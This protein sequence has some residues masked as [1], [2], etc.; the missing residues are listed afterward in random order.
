MGSRHGSPLERGA[1][2]SLGR[3]ARLALVRSVD[4]ALQAK[5]VAFGRTRVNVDAVDA[6]RRRAEEALDLGGFGRFH[7][8]NLQICTGLHRDLLDYGQ[9]PL[10]TGAA[11]EVEKFNL[12]AEWLSPLAFRGSS[13]VPPMR[14]RFHADAHALD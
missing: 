8:P 11:A 12:Q 7:S 10:V 14:L 13:D 6:Q 1:D 2:P 4:P 9:K 3:D 5:V